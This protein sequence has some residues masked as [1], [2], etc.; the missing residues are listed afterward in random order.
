MAQKKLDEMENHIHIVFQA[1]L[2]SE[3]I[4]GVSTQD[5]MQ[6][7]LQTMQHYKD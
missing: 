1:I 2:D 3:G 7:I 4:E 6:K 5:K